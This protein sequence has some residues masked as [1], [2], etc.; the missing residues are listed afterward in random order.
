MSSNFK[1]SVA[2][3]FTLIELLIVVI[4]LAILAAIAIPQ[5]SAST[6]DAQMAALDSNLSTVRTALEQYKVQHTGNVYPGANAAAGAT[7]CPAGGAAITTAAAN[8]KDSMLAQLR[9]YSNAAGAVCTVGDTTTY[10]YGPYLRQGVPS[11]PFSNSAEVKVAAVGAPPAAEAA[12]AGW[13][14]SPSTGQFIS[15]NSNADATGST[16][17]FS[18]H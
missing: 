15:N 16:R 17:K 14:Y 10:K 7:S 5:F 8:S 18:D 11:E 13:A 4:I 2:R 6:S 1:R 3:G 12:G 9:Y